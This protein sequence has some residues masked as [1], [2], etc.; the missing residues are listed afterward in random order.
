MSYP[1]HEMPLDNLIHGSMELPSEYINETFPIIYRDLHP[2]PEE[3]VIENFSMQEKHETTIFTDPAAAVTGL[4][5]IEQHF[6]VGADLSL[7]SS[8]IAPYPQAN[9]VIQSPSSG[10]AEILNPFA[11]RVAEPNLVEVDGMKEEI[12]AEF[13]LDSDDEAG[14]VYPEPMEDSGIDESFLSELDTVGDFRVESM[15]LNQQVLNHAS[16]SDSHANRNGVAAD[17]VISPRTSDIPL[18]MSDSLGSREQSPSV[19]HINDAEF[20]LSFEVSHGDP[21]QTVYNPQ[22]RI[23]E[24]SQF[25]AID[26]ELKPPQSETEMLSDDTP[27]AAI[28]GAGSSDT[29]VTKNESMTAATDPEITVLDAKSLEDI[30]DAFKLV[31]DSAV[32][33]VSMD[34]ETSHIVGVDVGSEPKEFAGQLHVIDAK[35]LDNIH[36][37]LKE[38]SDP[39][40]NSHLEENENKDGYGGTAEFSRHDT[41]EQ[42]QAESQPNVGDGRKASEQL[43]SASST[44]T[45]KAKT[46]GD[47]VSED[48]EADSAN[49]TVQAMEPQ[50]KKDSEQQ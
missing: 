8:V 43:E 41:P 3:R 48:L 18:T 35:S 14:K 27:S 42:L 36:A 7:S 16:H 30:E 11:P 21:E 47:A 45:S 24:G 22:R 40:V 17:P 33:E 26:T 4:H 28:L 29:E 32:A 37:T 23:L 39:V 20:S 10:P 50:G 5:V 13:L 15:G 46:H 49:S 38:H 1:N 2:I 31:N 34:A 19:D 25:E 6:D 9:D 44:S 12:A